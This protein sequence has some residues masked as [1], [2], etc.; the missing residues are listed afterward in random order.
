M[1]TF[2]KIGNLDGLSLFIGVAF[3][4]LLFFSSALISGSEVAYFSLSP[5]QMAALEQEDTSSGKRIHRLLKRPEILLATIL[6]ANNLVNIALVIFSFFIT[7]HMTVGTPYEDWGTMANAIITTTLLVLLGEVMPK[8]YATHH[9]LGLARFTSFPLTIVNKLL[10]PFSRLLAYSTRFIE[11]KVDGYR[12]KKG[13]NMAELNDAIDLV[14]NASANGGEEQQDMD[15]LKGLVEFRD[16]IV[17]QIMCS[18]LDIFAINKAV[19]FKELC[20]KVTNEGY[21]RVPIFE[22]GIDNIVGILYVKDLLEYLDA[23]ADFDWTVLIKGAYFIPETMKIDTLLKK[24]QKERTHLAII[25][26]EYSGTAGLITLEDILE[27]IVGEIIDEH[28]EEETDKYK[29]KNRYNYEFDGRTTIHDMCKVMKIDHH[30]FD[31]VDGDYDSVAGLLLEI[32]QNFPEEKD[33]IK[34]KRFEFTVLKKDGN[35]IDTVHVNIKPS[36]LKDPVQ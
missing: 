21:S 3:M 27:E 8:V 2:F 5:Q 15:M 33:K 32:N 17:R 16:I 35:R 4:I 30:S 36:E 24:M 1:L 9:N 20:D 26:D 34:Y 18:R 28:D 6:I 31:A 13:V 19:S 23:P 11:Q 12:S 29:K 22:E 7:A 25:V 10:Q 14:A